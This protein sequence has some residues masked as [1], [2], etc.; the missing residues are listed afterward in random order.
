M[1]PKEKAQELVDKY[2][3]LTENWVYG[4]ND[5]NHKKQ[6]AM[7]AVDEILN[8]KSIMLVGGRKYWETVKTEIELL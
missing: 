7:I 4:I 1:T 8:N 6:C 3:A 5:W 2:V